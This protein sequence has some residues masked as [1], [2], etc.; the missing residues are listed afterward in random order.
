ME[1]EANTHNLSARQ[2]QLRQQGEEMAPRLQEEP[3]DLCTL[4]PGLLGRTTTNLAVIRDIRNA[5]K[6]QQ[7][8]LSQGRSQSGGN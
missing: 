1:I 7:Q 6:M 2:R 4:G 5:P 3:Q 8:Y